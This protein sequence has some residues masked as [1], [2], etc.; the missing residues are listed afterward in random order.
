MHA[1]PVLLGAPPNMLFAPLYIFAICT[2]SYALYTTMLVVYSNGGSNSIQRVIT[3]SS[4]FLKLKLKV[5]LQLLLQLITTLKCRRQYSP[6]INPALVS[7]SVGY[8]KLPSNEKSIISFLLSI[9][10]HFDYK[11][12]YVPSFIY[13]KKSI[14]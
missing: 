13:G 10:S 4:V 8:R 7:S 2:T 12:Y 3:S 14:F 6:Y 11:E 9:I 1:I 5:S